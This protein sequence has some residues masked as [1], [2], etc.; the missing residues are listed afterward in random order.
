MTKCRD[1]EQ[2]MLPKFLRLQSAEC[3]PVAETPWFR[4]ACLMGDPPATDST[5][6]E[7]GNSGE[8]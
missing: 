6:R 7:V 1:E 4:T 2:I 3:R 8:R 5:H